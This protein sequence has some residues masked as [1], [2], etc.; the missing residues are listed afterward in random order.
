MNVAQ[1][2]NR[3]LAMEVASDDQELLVVTENGYGKRTALSDYPRKGR[4][5]MGVKTIALTENKGALAGAL[6]VREHEE[7]VFISARRDGPAH[8]R[9]RHQPL[10]PRL[11]GR[12]PD[13]PQGRRHGQRDRP[14]RR[15]WCGRRVDDVAP[16]DRRSSNGAWSRR[17]SEAAGEDRRSPRTY[18]DE[19]EPAVVTVRYSAGTRE[20]R[21]SSIG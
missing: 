16:E 18:A 20:R 1:P 14:R 12:A 4:G 5:T 3:V 2:G 9:P 7:L 13:E 17:P 11:P 6:V 15:D 19:E 8:E 10:R 21:W